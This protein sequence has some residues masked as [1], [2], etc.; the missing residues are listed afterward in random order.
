[1]HTYG[2]RRQQ[3]RGRSADSATEKK[4]LKFQSFDKSNDA[5]LLTIYGCTIVSFRI[6]PLFVEKRYFVPMI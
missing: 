5:A 4:R 2:G 3:T 1:M 6:F